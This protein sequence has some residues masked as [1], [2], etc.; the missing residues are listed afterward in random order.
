MTKFRRMFSDH[1]FSAT[2]LNRRCG[3]ILDAALR[4]PVTITR[5]DDAFALLRRDVAAHLS[6]VAH[7][8]TLFTE[9]QYAILKVRL[10]GDS[11]PYDHPYGWLKAFGLD[12]LKDME[13]E[14][15]VSLV[16][17]VNETDLEAVETSLYEWR[18]SAIAI[19]DGTLDEAFAKESN[20]VPLTPPE[21]IVINE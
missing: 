10:E 14:L 3:A 5:K 8:A 19:L 15:L 9:A 6:A 4:G 20:P 17:V 7:Q 12:D 2:D 1:L 18:E 13:A 16:Q 11:M 21:D